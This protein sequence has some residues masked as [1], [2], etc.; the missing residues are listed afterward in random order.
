MHVELGEYAEAERALR[1][2]LDIAHR[3]RLA[4]LIAFAK[5]NLGLALGR[6]G[7]LDEGRR[8]EEEAVHAYRAEGN[9]R[10]EGGSRIYLATILAAAGDLTAAEEQAQEAIALSAAHPPVHAHALA[11]LADIW[12]LLGRARDAFQ[13]AEEALRLLED[14]GGIEDGE[15]LVRLVHAVA[16]GQLGH[17]PAARTAIAK[18]RDRLLARAD[19]IASPIWRTSFLTRVPENART[20]TL[21]RQ[22]KAAGRAG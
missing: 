17:H 19:K 15:A 22:W 8:L 18:A 5:H 14:I 10:L 11:T 4:G 1:E 2:A 7:R 20:L 12:L 13:P 6:Q 21:A 3:Y 16:L 9:R